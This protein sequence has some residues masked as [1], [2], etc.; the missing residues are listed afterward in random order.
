MENRIFR[1][2]MKT[3]NANYKKGEWVYGDLVYLEDGKRKIPCIYGKGEVI[4]KTIGQESGLTDLDETKI[5]D[6]DILEWV[7]TDGNKHTVEVSFK[8]GCYVINADSD[9]METLYESLELGLRV[10]GTIHDEK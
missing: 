8:N 6:G 5:F 3:E 9:V 4:P 7:D 10:I 2:K 1:G